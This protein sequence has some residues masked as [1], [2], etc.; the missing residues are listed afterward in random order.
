MQLAFEELAQAPEQA[1]PIG[2]WEQIPATQTQLLLPTGRGG[3]VGVA[4]RDMVY[5]L[6]LVESA[7]LP[8]VWSP[9]PPA[10]AAPS[11]RSS[12]L[13]CL[14]STS[15]SEGHC[16]WV[17]DITSVP[18]ADGFLYLAVV[19]DAFS[20]RVVGWSIAAHMRTE[21]ALNA[22][23][24]ALA[25][26]RPPEGLIH[27][28]DHG[29]QYTAMAFAECCRSAGIRQSMGSVGD[30]FDNALAESFFATVE[31]EL[32]AGPALRTHAEARTALFT[33]IEGF[34]NRRRRHSALNYLSPE[35]YERGYTQQR[36]IA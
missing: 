13:R 23:G 8:R 29:S 5:H 7:R 3:A 19:L 22:L 25:R 14:L 24:M 11:P 16:D 10:A 30:C 26:R 27:H 6:P 18:T 12:A 20:R 34:Y 17:I 28:S 1:P 2:C 21:L 33:Y 35:A 4:G 32:L 9:A 31:C 36:A 15:P